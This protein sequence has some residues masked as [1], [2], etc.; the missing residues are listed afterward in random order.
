[1]ILKQ[2]RKCVLYFLDLLLGPHYTEHGGKYIKES[3]N[4]SLKS[5]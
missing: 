2:K 1:M 3:S 5:W 4:I